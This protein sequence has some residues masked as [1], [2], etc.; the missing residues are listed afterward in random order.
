MSI[1]DTNVMPVGGPNDY[2]MED[3]EVRRQKQLLDEAEKKKKEEEAAAAVAQEEAAQ[4]KPQESIQ[5]K[6]IKGAKGG[7]EVP[8]AIVGGVGDFIQDLDERVTF[9]EIPDDLWS[10]QNQTP[11]GKGLRAIASQ[12]VP[13]IGLSLLTRKGITGGATKVFGPDSL[14]KMPKV[15]KYFGEV[16]VAEAA[17]TAITEISREGLED[18]A[19]RML[20]DLG[21]PTPDAITTLDTD[22]PDV[23]RQ[24]NH[25]EGLGFGVLSEIVEW[26]VKGLRAAKGLPFMTKIEPR[27]GAAKEF[28]AGMQAGKT[29]DELDLESK[30]NDAEDARED[31]KFNRALQDIEADPEGVRPTPDVNT[32]LYETHEQAVIAR[33]RDAA[34]QNDID[35]ARIGGDIDSEDGRLGPIMDSAQIRAANDTDELG[36]QARKAL[37]EDYKKAGVYDVETMNGRKITY[38]MLRKIGDMDDFRTVLKGGVD[39]DTVAAFKQLLEDS[40][41]DLLAGTNAKHLDQVGMRQAVGAAKILMEA[42]DPENVRASARLARTTAGQISDMATAVRQMKDSSLDTTRQEELMLEMLEFATAEIKYMSWVQGRGLQLLN[43]LKNKPDNMTRVQL[44]QEAQEA[45]AKQKA[46][47]KKLNQFIRQLRE[48]DPANY[49]AFVAAYEAT[50]GRVD[51]IEALNRYGESKLSMGALFWNATK[52]SSMFVRGLMSTFY[53]S[54][55]SSTNTIFSAGLG[56]MVN[57]FLK[58]S[59]YSMG[60]LMSRDPYHMRRAAVAYGANFEAMHNG[61]NHAMDVWKKMAKDPSSVKYAVREEILEQDRLGIQATELYAKAQAEKGNYAPMLKF[62]MFKGLIDI[63]NWLIF[64]YSTNAMTSMDAFTRAALATQEARFRAYDELMQKNPGRI[65]FS[66]DEIKGVAERIRTEM[67]GKDGFLE[68][69]AVERSAREITLNLDT[70]LSNDINSLLETVPIL[71]TAIT[72]PRTS[73]NA[74]GFALSHSSASRLIGFQNDVKRILRADETKDLALAQEIMK[75]RGKPYSM[76]EWKALVYETKGR[77]AIGDMVTMAAVVAAAAGLYTGSGPK[78]EKERRAWQKLANYQ[79]MS[80]NI[81]KYQLSYARIEPFNLYLSVI[82]DLVQFT[83]DNPSPTTGEW[84]DR[85]ASTLSMSITDKALLAGIAPLMQALQGDEVAI[86]KWLG[87]TG[88][89][90]APWSGLRNQIGQILKPGMREMEYS[91][92]EFIRNRNSFMDTVDPAGALPYAYDRF[93][94]EVVRDTSVLQ[95]ALN[96]STPIRLNETAEPHRRWLM[97][98]GYNKMPEFKKNQFGKE[99]SPQEKSMLDKIMGEQ[100]YLDKK[101]KELY[102]NKSLRAERRFYEKQRAAGKTSDELPNT[103]VTFRLIDQAFAEAQKMAEAQLYSMPEFQLQKQES[104]R[105]KYLDRAQ[106]R[107][108]FE[109]IQQILSIPK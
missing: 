48:E 50:N 22:S 74:L 38:E 5:D 77:L 104:I 27:D 92:G 41:V 79:P 88:N 20:R 46:D 65:E 9:L 34:R 70:K 109:A 33:P 25:F 108:D 82:A 21:V 30:V 98:I 93:T 75:E 45:M 1:F 71:R 99:Y 95:R 28:E 19:M 64:R 69:E 66:K 89:A 7:L 72:F 4:A 40:K 85:I 13:T 63:N 100:G 86:N 23:K 105:G 81:G 97:E 59:A 58:S 36:L 17:G 84:I 49:R 55:L 14:A 87:Q 10:P 76:E 73:L 31:V 24:K 101:I 68:D 18:N 42:L 16:G 47:A 39:D 96:Y 51:T 53:N 29:S 61:F 56:N 54:L 37:V 35:A 32:P 78:T 106:K 57:M 2:L 26:T 107:G 15:A 60:S 3:E 103:Q 67:F 94:G 8:T 90:V 62:R 44:A 91:V 52:D 102:N 83:G 80:F 11:W 43:A 12:L 6:I